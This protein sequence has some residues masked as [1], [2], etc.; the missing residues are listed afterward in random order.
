[1]NVRGWPA[2]YIAGGLEQIDRIEAIYRLKAYDCRIL[3]STDLVSHYYPRY[4][5]HQSNKID[6]A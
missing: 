4:N 5:G 1:M 3:I 2:T 6:D